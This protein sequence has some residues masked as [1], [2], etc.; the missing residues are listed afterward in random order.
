MK[1]LWTASFAFAVAA[2]ALH[3]WPLKD[4]P[5][6]QLRRI[7][8]DIAALHPARTLKLDMEQGLNGLRGSLAFREAESTRAEARK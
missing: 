5:S 7:G 6:A 2:L 1:F 4:V 8:S 3:L